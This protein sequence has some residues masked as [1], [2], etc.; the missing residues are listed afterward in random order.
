MV[1]KQLDEATRWELSD[2]ESIDDY[3]LTEP[4]KELAMMYALKLIQRVYGDQLWLDWWGHQK[5][6]DPLVIVH[7]ENKAHSYLM[8]LEDGGRHHPYRDLKHLEGMI[9]DELRK[10]CA[11]NLDA[12]YDLRTNPYEPRNETGHL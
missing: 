7:G 6:Y 3:P 4:Q 5:S 8:D 10:E 2:A 1:E 9:V 11:E 12:L